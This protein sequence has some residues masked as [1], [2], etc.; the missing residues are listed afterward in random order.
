[1]YADASP[2]EVVRRFMAAINDHDVEAILALMTDDHRYT[3]ATGGSISGPDPL[4]AAWQGYFAWFPNYEISAEEVIA[5][6]N[7]VAVFGHAGGTF[8]LGPGSVADNTWYLPAA[9]LADVRGDRVAHWRVFCDTEPIWTIMRRVG[10]V[11]A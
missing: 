8:A 2:E 11:L 7:R 10:Q 3:D 6:G 9:W 1:M 5:S 4:R